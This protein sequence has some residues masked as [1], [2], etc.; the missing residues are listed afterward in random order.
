MEHPRNVARLV[1]TKEKS[2]PPMRCTNA[3]ALALNMGNV[4]VRGQS[5]IQRV[6]AKPFTVLFFFTVS[7]YSLYVSFCKLY[8]IN[9]Y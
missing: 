9:L 6:K 4:G 5:T 1:V 7:L 8:K 2:A 3:N